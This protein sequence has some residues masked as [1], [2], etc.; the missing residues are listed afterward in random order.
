MTSKVYHDFHLTCTWNANSSW[1]FNFSVHY[2]SIENSIL[3]FNVCAC[4]S[5]VPQPHARSV[6]GR[7][8]VR[9]RIYKFVRVK[10]QRHAKFR[11][12][13]RTVKYIAGIEEDN[14]GDH[15][16]W[17]FIALLELYSH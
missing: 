9:L 3:I 10:K 8:R 16:S 13:I 7:N 5:G 11:T 4:T 17:L 1:R 6:Q 14:R 15:R 12:V 2:V